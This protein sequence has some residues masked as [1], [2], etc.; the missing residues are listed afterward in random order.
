[1]ATLVRSI[2]V[3]TVIRGYHVYKEIWS[4]TL[5]E[6]LVCSRET[7][8][9]HDRFAVSVLKRTVTVGHV[10]K[11][12][13]SI[14]S[15]FLWRSGTVMCEVTGGRQYSAD[16][17]QGGLEVPCKL[18]FTCDDEDYLAIVKK[19]LDLALRKKDSKNE[20]PEMPLKKIKLEPVEELV[21][22]VA[23]PSQSSTDSEVQGCSSNL[24]FS[25]PEVD[26][27]WVKTGRFRLLLSHKRK[28]LSG[29]E[30]NDVIINFAQKLLKKQFPVIG[31]LQN[32]V[33]QAKKQN[34]LGVQSC[35][36]VIHSRG[37]HWIV[38]SNVHQQ[39]PNKVIV[40]DS[41]YDSIDDRTQVIIHELFGAST[42]HH[43]AKVHK[44][45][46]VR[47]CG[48][49]AIAFATA[50]C[51]KQDLHRPFQQEAMRLHL[52]QCFERGVCLPFPLM[53][54]V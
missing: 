54:D 28:I 26:R 24:E 51:F 32:T 39:E 40:Y 6:T 12:I 9:Y 52:V 50:I 43:L 2:E 8:N 21:I 19:L 38:A 27:E 29:E 37:N 11:K 35:L 7:D 10:P 53:C 16:L 48:L 1:M 36:Q 25:A 41:L 4:A 44:Q 14:C 22:P 23:E 17:E 42:K 3:D 18:T 13:S 5:G 33:L 45:Q 34:E 49:F 31:G 15:L 20:D 30:L 47:D 46:G